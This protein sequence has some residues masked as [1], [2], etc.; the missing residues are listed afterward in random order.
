M[1]LMHARRLPDRDE[2]ELQWVAHAVDLLI[3]RCVVRLSTLA[4]EMRQ[5]LKSTKRKEVNI[6]PMGCLQNLKS[7]KRY[8]QYWKQFVCYCLRIVAAEEEEK[9][10]NTLNCRNN[11]STCDDGSSN[12][13]NDNSY[14]NG[15]T[16]D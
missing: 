1:L 16:N 7:Q 12:S 4:L 6:Q 15:N 9:I 2:K 5:W 8:A 10:V 11:S 3:K 14:S 13:D